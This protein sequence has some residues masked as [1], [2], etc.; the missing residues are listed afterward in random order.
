MN[1][2][3]PFSFKVK[4]YRQLKLEAGKQTSVDNHELELKILELQTVQ[5]RLENEIRKKEEITRVI[6]DSTKNY[7]K[8]QEE[9]DKL[10]QQ[11]TATD[12]LLKKEENCLLNLEKEVIE[13]RKKIPK[14]QYES[15][16]ITE[17]L[18]NYEDDHHFLW[19]SQMKAKCIK[20]LRDKF[21]GVVCRF[22]AF[23]FFEL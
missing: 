17:D 2:N 10:Q 16:K 8:L 5:N 9:I 19:R 4:K 15:N 12:T 6:Q 3:Y 18:K 21:P 20:N 11:F 13:A 23:K 7:Q 22:S 1:S 14:L